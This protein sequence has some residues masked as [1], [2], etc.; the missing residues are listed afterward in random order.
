ML[1]NE[2]I[3]WWCFLKYIIQLSY[4]DEDIHFH[5]VYRTKFGDSLKQ[6]EDKISGLTVLEHR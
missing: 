6:S 5:V 1:K 2:E 3:V 4:K